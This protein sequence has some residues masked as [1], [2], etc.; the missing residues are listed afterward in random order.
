[1]LQHFNNLTLVMLHTSQPK[2]STNI[3]YYG[4]SLSLLKTSALA[5]MNNY[6]DITHSYHAFTT[7]QDFF[8]NSSS[9]H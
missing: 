9:C 5:S 7:T 6:G 8:L 3:S 4:L 1:M 2:H